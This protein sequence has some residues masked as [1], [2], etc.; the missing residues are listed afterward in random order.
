MSEPLSPRQ[1]EL[2]ADQ[3]EQGVLADPTLVAREAAA[4]AAEEMRAAASIEALE[5]DPEYQDDFPGGEE[6]IPGWQQS[7]EGIPAPV[8]ILTL[9]ELEKIVENLENLEGAS[10]SVA[11]PAA[12]DYLQGACVVLGMGFTGEVQM[13]TLRVLQLYRE[14]TGRRS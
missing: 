3:E 13:M 11:I 12:Q 4:L 8:E 9:I 10:P 7:Y 5:A 14:A 1:R 2:L 6:D